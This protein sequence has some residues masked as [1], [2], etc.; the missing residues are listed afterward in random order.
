MVA[1]QMKYGVKVDALHALQEGIQT[2]LELSATQ[3]NILIKICNMF[4][5]CKI[6]ML[7][8]FKQLPKITIHSIAQTA[9]TTK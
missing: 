6:N 9:H 2:I 3:K 1:L 4:L 5:L 7:L 8:Q